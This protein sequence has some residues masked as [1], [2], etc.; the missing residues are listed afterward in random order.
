MSARIQGNNWKG[1]R[2]ISS[3]G[4]ICVWSPNHPAATPNHG[5][6]YEHRLMAEAALGKVLPPEAEVHHFND[7]GSDNAPGNIVLCQ[8]KTYH[9]L[10][11]RRTR[12]LNACGHPTWVR[13]LYCRQYG[14]EK[15]MY[16][17]NDGTAHHRKCRN[18]AL[19]ERR[20]KTCH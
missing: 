17:G 6:I 11:H 1:G 3:H 10:L 16:M 12:A 7:I 13:C 5:Y 19:R 18:S 8:D 20:R 9:K 14:P 2:Y 4:Y 15:D